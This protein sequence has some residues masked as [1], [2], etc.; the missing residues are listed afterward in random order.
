MNTCRLGAAGDIRR[1]DGVFVPAEPHLQRHRHV[2]RI[3]RRLD[4][5]ERMIG[6]AHQRRAGITARYLLGRAS[7]I[8]IDDAGAVIGRDLRRLGHEMRLT[9][10]KLHHMRNHAGIFQPRPGFPLLATR[11]RL[12]TISV[13]T[14]PAP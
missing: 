12:A 4:Q 5:R 8:D 6:I 7:H 13:T 1:I 14:R 10:G 9:P 3:D 2:D 11:L